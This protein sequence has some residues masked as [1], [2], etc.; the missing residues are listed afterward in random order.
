MI[1][2]TTC[3]YAIHAVCRLAV[4]APNGY[5]RVHEIC[6]NSDLPPYFVSK[7]LRDLVRAGI[8]RSAKGRNGG[9]G[10]ATRPEAV[11]LIDIVEAIDGLRPYRQCVAGLA[12][13]NDR[14]PCPQ[15]DSFKPVRQRI[16]SYLTDT[17]VRQM[18]DA[19]VRKSELIGV[20][21]PAAVTPAPDPA[22]PAGA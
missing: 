11:R 16:V 1:Y 20:P 21:P 9:F 18:A 14:Q 12:E 8:C 4:I 5:A 19:I 13:C 10:L 15:H 6:A 22:P 3:A 7:I 17:T 2:S